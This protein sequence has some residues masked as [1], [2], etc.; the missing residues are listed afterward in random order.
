MYPQWAHFKQDHREWKPKPKTA[1]AKRIKKAKKNPHDET[2]DPYEK[3]ET[4][5]K[6]EPEANFVMPADTSSTV[7]F[8][9]TTSD[10]TWYGGSNSGTGGGGGGTF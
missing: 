2:P 10:N 5:I 4:K 6:I 8:T 9:T 1:T 7:T 3:Y